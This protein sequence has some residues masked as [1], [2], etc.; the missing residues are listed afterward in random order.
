MKKLIILIITLG[1]L[2][3]CVTEYK[4]NRKYSPKIV[5]EKVIQYKD[6]II[7]IHDTTFIKADTVI[8][9]DTVI[10]DKLTGLITSNKL[11]SKTDFA[12]AWAQV[13]DSRLYLEL[14]QNDTAIAKKIAASIE[15]KYITETKTV[16][17]IKYIEHWYDKPARIVSII[18]IL[19][20]LI[21]IAMRVIKS[22]IKPF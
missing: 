20:V 7:Y 21:L 2:S 14:I 16:E 1:F 18:F 12:E 4:C 13:I 6:T 11:Y 9:T 17:V 15:T 8:K 22:Y 3:S 19:A 10:V 5:I